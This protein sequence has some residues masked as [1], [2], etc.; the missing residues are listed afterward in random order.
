MTLSKEDQIRIITTQLSLLDTLREKMQYMTEFFD[1]DPAF[2][3]EARDFV[4][5][6]IAKTL[7]HPA[8]PKTT[9]TKQ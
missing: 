8:A 4:R 2:S 7:T 3:K 6:E 5:S 9:I 1:T